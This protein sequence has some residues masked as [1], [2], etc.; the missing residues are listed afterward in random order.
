MS[1]GTVR[2]DGSLASRVDRALFYVESKL[3]LVGGIVILLAMLFSV[4]N[5]LGRKLFNLPIPG[6]IDWMEQMVPIMAFLG[7]AYCQRLGGHIRMDFVVTKLKGRW[8]WLFELISVILMLVITL[9]LIYGSWEHADRA[10]SFGDSTVDIN[11][12]TWPIKLLVPIMLVFLALRLFL[13]V[14]FYARA[15]ASGEDAPVAVPIP[16]DPAAIAQR[17]AESVSGW[18]G[19][20]NQSGG[21]AR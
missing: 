7:I 1:S 19:E 11:L 4:A 10:W 8:L 18:R 21:G 20:N 13:Q 9:P 2:E 17:E 16:E 3:T 6:Y 5:I 12:P 14:W 15:V